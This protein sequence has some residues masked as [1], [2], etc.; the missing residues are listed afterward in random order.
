M[1]SA[2]LSAYAMNKQINVIGAGSC[3]LW[4]ETVNWI[5]TQNPF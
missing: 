1:L 3:S 5:S 2:L 4:A